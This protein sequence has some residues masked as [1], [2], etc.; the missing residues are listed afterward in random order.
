VDEDFGQTLAVWGTGEGPYLI[1]PLLGPAT[2][3]DGVGRGVDIF[4]DPL[5]YVLLNSDQEYI[6]PAIIATTAVDLRSRNLERLDEIERTSVDFYAAIRS[7]YRQHRID[8]INNGE[9]TGEESLFIT[10]PFD[11]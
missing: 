3:R 5:T 6:G 1:L 11:Y 10:N 4:L 9:A 2:V 7:L 8:L